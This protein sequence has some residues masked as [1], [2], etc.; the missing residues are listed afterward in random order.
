MIVDPGGNT[1]TIVEHVESAGLVPKW[2]VLTHC[3]GDHIGG[4]S[5]VKERYPEAQIAAL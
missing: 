1:D 3:H 5:Q 4:L 2:I